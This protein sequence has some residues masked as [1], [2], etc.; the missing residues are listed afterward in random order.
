MSVTPASFSDHHRYAHVDQGSDPTAFV[1]HLDSITGLTAIQAYKRET[2]ALLGVQEGSRILDVGCGAGDDVR[3]LGALVGPTGRVVG[4]DSSETM[5]ATAR[6]RVE[7][8]TLPV[9]FHTGDVYQLAWA[10]AGFDGVRAD[11]LLH[12]LDEPPRAVAEMVRVTRS[13][14]RVVAFEP[15]F[16]V[17]VLDSPD[18]MMARRAVDEIARRYPQPACGRQ[19][20]RWFKQAGLVDVIALPKSFVFDAATFETLFGLERAAQTLG[21]AGIRWLEAVKQAAAGGVFF[22]AGVGF[23]VCGRKP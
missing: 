14:G 20:S 12:H 22:G 23:T 11:R 1:R 5:L 19:L 9:E 8:T 13:G 21:E 6:A 18:W 17:V 3:E 16:D 15:D 10:D 4:V 7:G 2:Y